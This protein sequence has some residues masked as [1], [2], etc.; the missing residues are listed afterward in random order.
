M[1]EPTFKFLIQS[2]KSGPIAIKGTPDGFVVFLGESSVQE[3]LEAR[4][5][6]Q[7]VFKKL[8]T[9]VAYLRESGVTEAKIYF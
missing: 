1:R 3:A 7:R 9:L 8:D 4:R 2:G 5:G 6:H